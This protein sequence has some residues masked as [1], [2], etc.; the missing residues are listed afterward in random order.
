MSSDHDELLEPIGPDQLAALPIDEVR[1]LRAAGT[2]VE[3]GLSYL[4]RMVQGAI[5]IITREHAHRSGAAP[6]SGDEGLLDELPGILGDHGRPAG[7]GRLP[8]TLEP[9]TFDMELAAEYESLIGDGHLARVGELDDAELDALL[10]QL[11][12]L[13]SR[14]SAKRRGYLDRID[15]LQSELTRRYQTGEATVDSLLRDAT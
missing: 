13:E 2:D 14:V 8:Q 1:R 6:T 5:D 7:V 4:R 15:A 9:T 10:A 11:G 12:D 3:T